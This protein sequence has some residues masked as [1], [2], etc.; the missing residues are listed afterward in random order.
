MPLDQHIEGGHSERQARLKI[1]PAP[2]HH[3]FAVA[4]ER[5]HRQDRLDE[6]AILP[7]P[8]ST[9][10]EVGRI[11]LGGMEG[12]IAQDDHASVDLSNEPLEGVI[13]DIGGTTRPSHDQPPLVEQQTEFPAHNPAVIGDTTWRAKLVCGDGSRWH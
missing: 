11:P 6:D 12:G 1:R 13:R 2:M 8:P 9:Q 3:F 10:F 4:D 7:L 5:Q